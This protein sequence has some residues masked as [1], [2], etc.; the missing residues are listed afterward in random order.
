MSVTCIYDMFYLHRA[1][2]FLSAIHELTD[3]FAS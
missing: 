2:S 1:E 3:L